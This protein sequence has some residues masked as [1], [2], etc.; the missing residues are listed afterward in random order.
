VIEVH[1]ERAIELAVP[2]KSRI[3]EAHGVVEYAS[4][5]GICAKCDCQ[6]APLREQGFELLCQDDLGPADPDSPDFEDP[7]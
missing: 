1:I 6:F 7:L 2:P 3:P 5:P 4:M